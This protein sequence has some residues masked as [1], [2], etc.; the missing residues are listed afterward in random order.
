MASEI[1]PEVSPNLLA[2]SRMR[3]DDLLD[4]EPAESWL[5]QVRRSLL[6]TW[7]TLQV[8]PA[9]CTLLLGAGFLSGNLLHR[10]QTAHLV[11]QPTSVVLPGVAEGAVTA[12][13][14]VAPTANPDVVEVTYNRVIAQTVQGRMEDPQIRQLLLTAAEHGAQNEVRAQSVSLLATECRTGRRCEDTDDSKGFRNA[15][16]VSLRYDKNASVRLKALEGL[17][18]Y[19][20]QDSRVRDAVLE[21]LMRD[22]SSEVRKQA[23][24]MLEPVQADASVRQVLHH[25][26]TQDENPYIRNVSMQALEGVDGIQ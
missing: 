7:H 9:L 6:S 23:I 26:S 21:S 1:R 13:S 14:S 20:A 22:S 17:Q 4:S 2:S 18:P 10:Y 19:I 12:V 3:L 25:V 5:A 24:G 11:Q 16:L 8:A 15:L